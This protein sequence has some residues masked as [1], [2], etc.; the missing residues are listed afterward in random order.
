MCSMFG[1]E[2]FCITKQQKM[3]FDIDQYYFYSR[4]YPQELSDDQLNWWF[5]IDD[6]TLYSQD[7]L[8]KEYGYKTEMEIL[9]SERFI[10]FAQV[11]T[12]LLEERYMAQF[13]PQHAK[14]IER[15]DGGKSFRIFIEQH[16]HTGHWNEYAETALKNAVI[17]WCK[18]NKIAYCQSA[19]SR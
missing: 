16:D 11:D 2:V 9:E 17:C 4:H 7:E 15:C 5:C 3:I 8:I 10:R 6:Y 19:L 13:Y 12:A 18:E 1:L 14:D